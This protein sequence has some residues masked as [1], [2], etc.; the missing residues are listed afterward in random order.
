[1]Y[2]FCLIIIQISFISTCSKSDTISVMQC[3]NL[4]IETFCYMILLILAIVQLKRRN[5]YSNK[6]ITKKTIITY[7]ILF[8]LLFLF[9]DT[10]FYGTLYI[11][12]CETLTRYFTYLTVFYYFVTKIA[13]LSKRKE[14]ML[15]RINCWIMVIS[16]AILAT[17]IPVAIEISQ[18][19]PEYKNQPCFCNKYSS[20]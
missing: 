10:L 5:K 19:N 20:H 4:S 17:Y 16:V 18:M 7:F 3:M 9:I 8:Q 2:V 15:K 11:H 12:Y 14:K 13:K 1:M 6:R